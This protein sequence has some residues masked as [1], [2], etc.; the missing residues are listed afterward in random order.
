M[1]GAGSFGFSLLIMVVATWTFYYYAPPAGR[2][3][4][5]YA[6]IALLGMAMGIGR[7]VDAITDPLI[8]QWSDKNESRWGRRIPFILFGSLPFVLSFLFIWT[9]PVGETSVI[10]FIYLVLM[11]SLFFLCYT[12]VIVPYSAILPE[13]THL[14]KE[15]ISLAA[16]QG[17]FR[18]VGLIVGFLGSSFLIDKIGFKAMAALLGGLAL[19]GFY[20]PVFAIKEKNGQVNKPKLTLRQ[21]ISQTFK[22]KSFKYF[23]AGYMFFWFAFTI[24]I[25]GIPYF[26][27]V[28]MGLGEGDVGLVMAPS[29]AVAILSFP[30]ISWLSKKR[31]KKFTFICS[32]SLLCVAFF[33]FPTIGHWPLGIS[34][35]LQGRIFMGLCAMPMAALFVLPNA[36][37]A[38]LVDY[39]EKITGSRRE[40]M[41]FGIE[42][43]LLKATIA[44][45]S[46][47]FGA[48]LGIFGYS[49]AQR[50]GILLL[51]PIAGIFVLLGLFIFSKYP[52]TK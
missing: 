34:R 33:L 19:V 49:S 31:G 32:L 25:L 7:I 41:Y 39:D 24:L 10:N 1:Y 18:A 2:R 3:L 11:L 45:S 51:G 28:L 9:P 8:A 42:G 4:T 48:L 17:F 44:L 27:T 22:N 5:T 30:L 23:V 50:V 12:I 40:A 15:R 36:M 43:L 21:S 20:C 26:V 52:I 6:P 37:V 29:V 16:W 14:P 46:L 47:F 35:V 13:L 38:D